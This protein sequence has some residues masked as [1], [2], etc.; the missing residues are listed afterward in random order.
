M[1]ATNAVMHLVRTGV[2]EHPERHE[3]SLQGF[4]MLRTYLSPDLRLHVW[5][6]DYRTPSVSDIH[7]HPWHFESI[8]LSGII[9]NRR[10]RVFHPH[11]ALPP[12]HHR[13][14]IMCGP[15]PTEHGAKDVTE[16]RLAQ[17]CEGVYRAGDVYR[18]RADELHASLPSPG[19]VTLIQQT[20]AD[21]DPERAYVYWP[22]GSGWVSAE[23]RP[24]TS[25]EVQRI[26]RR[27]LDSWTGGDS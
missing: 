9:E 11:D 25:E 3:W 2:L 8:V 19:A 14:R 5:D 17:W 26:T 4:G 22:I 10:Y 15:N 18:M 16:V 24:A 13:G 20:K 1:I 12:S 7:D 23:P 27:A 6:P 21:K